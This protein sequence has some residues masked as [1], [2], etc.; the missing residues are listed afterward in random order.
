MEKDDDIIVFAMYD[1][2]IKANM[3][4][5]ILESNGVIAGVMGDSIANTLM[6]GF[7]QGSMRVVVLRKDLPLAR[8]I[9]D[10]NPIE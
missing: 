3:V 9:M 6:K 10:S 2:P 4:K 8:E 1:D 7:T 5:D